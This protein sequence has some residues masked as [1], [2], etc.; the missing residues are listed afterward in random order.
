MIY[1]QSKF[2]QNEIVL[3]S[4]HSASVDISMELSILDTY[5]GSSPIPGSKYINL[6]KVT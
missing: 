4:M 2:D 5:L 1:L 3:H 6:G